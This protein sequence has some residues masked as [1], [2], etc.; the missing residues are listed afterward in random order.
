MTLRYQKSIEKYVR[1]KLGKIERCKETSSVL[2]LVFSQ[3]VHL[4]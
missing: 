2:E 4:A 3:S 1:L